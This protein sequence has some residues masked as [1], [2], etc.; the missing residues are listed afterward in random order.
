VFSAAA[1]ASDLEDHAAVS[2]PDECPRL[3]EQLETMIGELTRLAAG[4]SVQ[5]LRKQVRE[6]NA[7]VHSE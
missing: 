7:A 4:L 3:V 2:R 5:S 6:G 1:A